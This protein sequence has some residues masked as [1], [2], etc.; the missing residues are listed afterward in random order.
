MTLQTLALYKDRPDVDT[1]VELVLG[2]LKS[3]QDPA[4]GGFVGWYG[5]MSTCSTAQ[6]VTALAA[7]EIDPAGSDWMKLGGKPR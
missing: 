5:V 1:V 2:W 7:L 4:T 6:V 3:K